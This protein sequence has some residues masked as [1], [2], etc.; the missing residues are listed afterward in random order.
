VKITLEQRLKV[1]ENWRNRSKELECGP[2]TRQFRRAEVA[3]LVGAI[4]TLAMFGYNEGTGF[5]DIM[6]LTGRSVL[7]ELKPTQAPVENEEPVAV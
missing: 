2:K 6:I 3:Y 5:F 4:D 1:V 7:D